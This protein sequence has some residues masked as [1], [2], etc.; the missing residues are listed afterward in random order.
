M[1]LERLGVDYE[2]ERELGA[3]SERLSR[4]DWLTL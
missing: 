3:E 1:T 4:T 2:E